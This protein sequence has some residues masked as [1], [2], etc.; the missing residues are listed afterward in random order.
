MDKEPEKRK[1]WKDDMVALRVGDLAAAFLI[2]R[3]TVY[4]L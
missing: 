1:G 2:A 4:I 3:A